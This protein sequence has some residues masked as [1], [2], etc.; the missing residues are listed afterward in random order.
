[1]SFGKN[2]ANNAEAE[3]LLI[4]GVVGGPWSIRTQEIIWIGL[5]TASDSRPFGVR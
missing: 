5:L 2:S 4:L 3:C 1:M